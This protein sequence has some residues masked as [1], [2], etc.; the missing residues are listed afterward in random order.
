MLL[1]QQ[2]DDPAVKK[3]YIEPFKDLYG[4]I[5]EKSG[6]ELK[7]PYDLLLM[8]FTFKTYEV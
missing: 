1:A 6:T 8:Y 7:D 2:R 3:K 4:Y 5:K